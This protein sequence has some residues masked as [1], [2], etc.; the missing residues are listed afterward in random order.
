LETFYNNLLV[1]DADGAGTNYTNG[2]NMFNA[3]T[4]VLVESR[5]VKTISAGVYS[6]SEKWS[7]T[8]ITYGDNVA[9][10]DSDYTVAVAYSTPGG[11]LKFNNTGNTINVGNN[12]DSSQY[13]LPLLPWAS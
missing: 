1:A 9:P 4:T 13:I 5:P 10:G 12:A 2:P 3:G 8:P 11:A 7:T 6:F